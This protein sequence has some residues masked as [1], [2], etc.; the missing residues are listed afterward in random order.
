MDIPVSAKLKRAVDVIFA[1]VQHAYVHY[2]YWVAL[3]KMLADNQSILNTHAWFLHDTRHAHSC[4]VAHSLMRLFDQHK[5][6]YGFINFL[7]GIKST[8]SDSEYSI[9]ADKYI[10]NIN[11][12]PINNMIKRLT[13]IRDETYAH[14]DKRS[15]I[16]N[17]SLNPP[18]QL[19]LSEI[20]ELIDFSIRIIEEYANLFNISHGYIKNCIAEPNTEVL[21]KTLEQLCLHKPVNP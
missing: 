4:V 1:D 11:T 21:L 6:A 8:H 10:T 3:D 20:K 14:I 2:Y 17:P 16:R 19:S 12:D 18:A 13:C 7:L 9:I 15:I 5:D